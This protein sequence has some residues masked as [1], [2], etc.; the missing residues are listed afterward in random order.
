MAQ[1]LFASLKKYDIEFDIGPEMLK[2]I[3]EYTVSFRHELYIK[4]FDKRMFMQSKSS[5]NTQYSDI[6]IDSEGVQNYNANIP[7]G[8]EE[9]YMNFTRDEQVKYRNIFVTGEGVHKRVLLNLIDKNVTTPMQE[10][11]MFL[12]K[13]PVKVRIDTLVEKK[14][15]F[16][17]QRGMFIWWRL[18]DPGGEDTKSIEN[19]PSVVKKIR[20]NP[21]IGKA[22]LTMEPGLFKRIVNL[23]GK[24]GKSGNSHTRGLFEI[25]VNTGLTIASGDNMR[26]RVL[27]LGVLGSNVSNYDNLGNR[28]TES[29]ENL[30]ENKV[31]SKIEKDV[32]DD[33]ID[34]SVEEFEDDDAEYG[35][36]IDSTIPE[37]KEE[38]EEIP[39]VKDDMF[40][41]VDDVPFL[42]DDDISGRSKQNKK[43]EEKKA[44]FED[45]LDKEEK[46]KRSSSKK[47]EEESIMDEAITNDLSSAEV[48]VKTQIWM[49]IPYLAPILKLNGLAPI[50]IE[51]RNGLPLVVTQKPYPDMTVMLTIAPRIETNEDTD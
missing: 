1:N 29:Y 44:R 43:K 42:T 51:M 25:D 11:L 41:N 19:M 32:H 40:A 18:M 49:E 47:K 31:E 2:S 46:K 22:V 50:L 39:A 27:K 38:Q 4:F 5:D 30:Y 3:M 14:I 24:P 8:L 45:D 26:G 12:G 21:N 15:E 28:K 33:N 7:E 9:R 37:E 48:E 20:S 36:N 16:V 35:S 6:T 23:G 17:L 34:N 13:N 10:L